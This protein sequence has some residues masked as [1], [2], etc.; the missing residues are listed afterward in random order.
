MSFLVPP[1]SLPGPSLGAGPGA[2]AQARGANAALQRRTQN[3]EKKN[4][5]EGWRSRGVW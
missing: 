3:G 2:N 5:T 4:I 1:G